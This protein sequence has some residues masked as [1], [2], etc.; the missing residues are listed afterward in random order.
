VLLDER[1]ERVGV[2]DPPQGARV[3]PDG[4]GEELAQL[5]AGDRVR[6]LRVAGERQGVDDEP[7]GLGLEARPVF[8]FDLV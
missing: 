4:A 5:G 6:A 2:G 1:A 7:E 3:R 8:G